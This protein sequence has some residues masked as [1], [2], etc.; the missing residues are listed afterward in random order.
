ML[1]VMRRFASFYRPYRR[2]FLLDFICAV[3]VASRKSVSHC[4]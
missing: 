2:L 3:G 4:L 1:L